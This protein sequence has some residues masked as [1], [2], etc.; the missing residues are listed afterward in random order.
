MA[1]VV[2]C[3]W[4][5]APHLSKSEQEILLA[6]IPPYQIKARTKGIPM[7]GSGA[8]YPIEEEDL[9]CDAFSIPAHWPRGFGLDV[10]WN[11]TAAVWLAWER[12]TPDTIYI[13]DC[14]RRGQVEPAIHLAAI[15]ARGS[16]IPGF[17][18]PAAKGRSQRDGRRLIVDYA[19][20]LWINEAENA[21]EAGLFRVYERMTTGRL[22]VFRHLSTWLEEFRLY[23]RDDKGKVV[24]QNDH[25]MDATRYAIMD[26]NRWATEPNFGSRRT[27]YRGD[28]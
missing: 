17:I 5:D 25:C 27:S 7:L 11:A 1:V 14:Y 2:N 23:R 20:K 15:T 13:Y 4:E 22:R 10:G 19:E 28:L 8:I 6:A 21:V 26:I 3:G 18:D 16:W 24:K 9:L 12:G